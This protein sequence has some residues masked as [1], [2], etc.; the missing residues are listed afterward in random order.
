[1]STSSPSPRRRRRRSR[2][3]L[4]LDERNAAQ[5]DLARR[6]IPTVGFFGYSLLAGLV[7][8]LGTVAPSGSLGLVLF[9]VLITPLM[10]PVIG[11]SLGLLL[12]APRLIGE[13]L[14]A[15]V[16]GGGLVLGVAVAVRAALVALSVSIPTPPAPFFAVEVLL[17]V[18]GALGTAQWLLRADRRVYLAN[19]LLAYA[20]YF[21]LVQIGMGHRDPWL[22]LLLF[23]FT[24]ALL[25]GAVAL[26][27]L[28]FRPA[29]WPVT[30]GATL[31]AGGILGALVFLPKAAMLQTTPPEGNNNVS[32]M[33]MPTAVVL[34]SP[35]PSAPPVP[36]ATPT[37]TAS[38]QPTTTP[39][40]PVVLPSPAVTD[41][42][43]PTPTIPPVYAI[44]NAPAEYGGAYVRED[45]SFNAHIL[46][47]IANGTLVQVVSDLPVEAENATW[48]EVYVPQYDLRGWMVQALLLRATP[49]PSW[50]ATP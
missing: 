4:S 49:A 36:T 28:G 25:A 35:T 44:V 14:G 27:Q 6:V 37:M 48:V 24:L 9:G 33:A 1:M 10:A 30:V 5:R 22:R 23:Q 26:W 41:T 43:S 17:A 39:T 46:R 16:V 42:P 50:E 13:S 20:L 11:L 45:P 29:H 19:A 15:L 7:I 2:L 47:S 21:P 12:G 31:L 8:A 18:I 3:P 38:P 40:P 34:V 32:V